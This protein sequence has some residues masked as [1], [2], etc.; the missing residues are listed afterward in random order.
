[1]LNDSTLWPLWL[2]EDVKGLSVYSLGYISP[3]TNW[4]GTA[5]PLLDEAAHVLRLLLNQTE[6]RE[7]PIA[8]VCH[9]LGG[10]IVKQV[11]RAANEQRNNAGIRA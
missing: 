5:M 10:L 9:S 11:L 1:M 3:P 4:L 2:A 8:F 7:G 6:L